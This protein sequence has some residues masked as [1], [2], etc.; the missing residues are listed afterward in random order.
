MRDCRSAV[1]AA[2]LVIAQCSIAAAN[3]QPVSRLSA[4][5]TAYCDR[6][7]TKDGTP[8]HE[9]IVAADP[10]VLPLGSVVHV[11][12]PE[13]SLSGVFTV[14]DTGSAVK[15]RIVD[16]FMWSCGRAK[17]F[18]RRSAIVSV[19]TRGRPRPRATR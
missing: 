1:L 4:T 5:A 14:R 3:P 11:H 12:V 19:L 2:V 8:V 16:I 7:I 18:G 10:R 17:L 13:L 6:G 15:G 9:G